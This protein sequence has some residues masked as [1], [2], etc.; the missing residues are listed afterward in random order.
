MLSKR[1]LFNPQRRRDAEGIGDR[2]LVSNRRGTTGMD[3]TILD[4]LTRMRREHVLAA[5]RGTSAQ[6]ALAAVP[7]PVDD[8]EIRPAAMVRARGADPGQS[9]RLSDGGQE[10]L[11]GPRLEARAMSK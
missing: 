10:S 6:T 1:F 5:L 2:Q 4:R 9:S 8:V 7:L 3:E 11:G